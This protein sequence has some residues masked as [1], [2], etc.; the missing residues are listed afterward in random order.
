MSRPGIAST[1]SRPIS[2]SLEDYPDDEEDED[3]GQE[4]RAIPLHRPKPPVASPTSVTPSP[5][6]PAATPAPVTTVATPP[7][8]TTPVAG[9]TATPAPTAPSIASSAPTPN[10]PRMGRHR[11]ADPL[12]NTPTT[13]TQIYKLLRAPGTTPHQYRFAPASTLAEAAAILV[14]RLIPARMSYDGRLLGWYRLGS[15]NGPLPADTRL[16]SV[17]TDEPLYL[18]FV[19]S[20]SVS[21]WVEV[22]EGPK[23]R[24]PVA[25]AMPMNML[26]DGLASMLDLPAGDWQ[27]TLEGVTL[28][29]FH[30]LEDRNPPPDARLVLRRA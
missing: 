29:A 5:P 26:V 1:V 25:T 28:G 9:P 27:V 20:R 16:E 7:P 21:L 30:I 6:P 12:R 10:R 13:T 24:L 14:G 18:H 22:Q 8:V 4:T 19:E 15:A 2:R 3:D 23:L 11:A 17:S